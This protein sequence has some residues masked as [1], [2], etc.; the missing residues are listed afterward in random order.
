[1]KSQYKIPTNIFEKNEILAKKQLLN[2]ILYELKGNKIKF[3][4]ASR[5][6]NQFES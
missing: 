1:M 3:F 2:Q 5:N 6:K 4:E